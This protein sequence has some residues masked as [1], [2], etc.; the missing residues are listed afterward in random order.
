MRTRNDQHATSQRS[1]ATLA[2]ASLMAAGPIAQ[3]RAEDLADLTM[4]QLLDIHVTT[5][6]RFSQD[7]DDAPASV[8]VITAQDIADYGWTSVLE[9]LESVPGMQA[10]DDRNYVSIG[11]R[12][13]ALPG[14][15]SNRLIMLVDGHRM[16]D[17][18]Y[19]SITSVP[20]PMQLIERIEV[21]R[22]PGSALYGSDALF[23]VVNVITRN[24]SGEPS[25]SVGAE[26]GSSESWSA[27]VTHH[28]EH[29]GWTVTMGAAS[30][31]SAGDRVVRSPGLPGIADADG[32]SETEIFIKA[33]R[34]RL[35]LL[36]GA[37]TQVKAVPTAS[38]GSIPAKGTRT[39]DERAFVEAQW[40][41]PLRRGT[42][43]ARLSLDAS[44]Y[45]GHYLYDYSAAQ[46]GSFLR[47]YHDAS[48]AEWLRGEVD[49]DVTLG[50]RVHFSV[51]ADYER[52]L[53]AEQRATDLFDG[54]GFLVDEPSTTWGVH[55]QAEIRLARRVSLVLGGKWSDLGPAGQA[56]SHRAALIV[57]PNGRTTIKLMH[58]TAFRG[59]TAYERSYYAA[60][61]GV[62]HPVPDGER[63][64]TSEIALTRRLT[65]QIELGVAAFHNRLDDVIALRED[66]DSLY[67]EN[68]GSITAKGLEWSLDGAW[69]SGWRLKLHGA[70][71]DAHDEDGKALVNSPK[72]KVHAGV[73]MPL[74][75]RRST[76]ALEAT[77]LGSRLTLGG[78]RTGSSHQ[79]ALQ[80]RHRD[81]GGVAGLDLTLRVTNALDADAW[82]VA[83][84]EHVQDVI[85]GPSRRV[86][87]GLRYTF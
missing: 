26:A 76:L 86:M 40:A 5:A 20:V 47:S 56:P 61:T 84:E 52:A 55:A 28:G 14:D 34:G 60:E 80:W 11:A 65:H 71:Q 78:Q 43:N 1:L 73:V 51:G 19:H 18:I 62:T 72:A 31:G 87:L 57:R 49:Y 15:Y 74:G 85:P 39:I 75:S 79:L 66:A 42:L 16:N 53:R 69:R 8:S 46:D 17:P 2:I 83:G 10:T 6:S 23:A 30:R 24:G 63:I 3:A 27:G 38:Y 45:S 4:E 44:E 77:W 13:F 32:S 70:F 9:A 35:T 12:G 58:G 7:L 37:N 41:Q 33:G 82:S 25:T 67:F 54:T 22:G 64:T 50:E 21:V 81:L 59:V 29:G 68:G 36:A 48:D